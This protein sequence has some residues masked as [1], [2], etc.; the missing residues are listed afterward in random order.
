MCTVNFIRTCAG[1]KLVE[2]VS[3]VSVRFMPYCIAVLAGLWLAV[4]AGFCRILIS[5]MPDFVNSACAGYKLVEQEYPVI[6]IRFLPDFDG[7]STRFYNVFY[8]IL[9]RFLPDFDAFQ[10]RFIGKNDFYSYTNILL[11]VV[12]ALLFSSTLPSVRSLV[13][14][15]WLPRIL[16]GIKKEVLSGVCDGVRVLDTLVED[17]PEMWQWGHL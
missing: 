13:L 9:M 14:L 3:Q 17:D 10:A 4:A 12:H 5:H 7:F 8:P 2:S 11:Y 16:F 6:T 1:Y 15:C